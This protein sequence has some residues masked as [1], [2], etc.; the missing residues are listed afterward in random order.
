MNWKMV[1][2][3]DGSKLFKTHNFTLMHRGTNYRLDI[4]EFADG[5][6]SGHGE[7]STDKSSVLESVSGTS[8]EDCLNA[9]IKKIKK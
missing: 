4:E 8:L 6:F 9:L 3:P 1:S 5:T 2:L 7:H